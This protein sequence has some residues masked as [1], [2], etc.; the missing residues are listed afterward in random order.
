MLLFFFTT[1]QP[2]TTPLPHTVLEILSQLFT[3]THTQS[4]I[5]P[6]EYNL[7]ALLVLGTKKKK[8]KIDMPAAYTLKP[9]ALGQEA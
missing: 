3:L 6:S 2:H 7:K 1:T 9:G 8:K 4:L 5:G